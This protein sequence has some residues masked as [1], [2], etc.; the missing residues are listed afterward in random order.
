MDENKISVTN[1]YT[2]WEIPTNNIEE[3]PVIEGQVEGVAQPGDGVKP[4]AKG[5]KQLIKDAYNAVGYDIEDANINKVF[6]M[7]NTDPSKFVKDFWAE[8]GTELPK[9]V[10]DNLQDKYLRIDPMK[11]SNYDPNAPKRPARTI[12]NPVKNKPAFTQLT[13]PKQKE[14]Q[15]TDAQKKQTVAL[16]NTYNSLDQASKNN[17]DDN[18]AVGATRQPD[19]LRETPKEELDHHDFM[20]TK[21]GK[22]LGGVA[23]VGSKASHGV[24]Q[25]LKG[26]AYLTGQHDNTQ[27][28]FD[29]LD[30]LADYGLTKSDMS[31]YDDNKIVS[32][33]GGLAEFAPAI[34]GGETAIAPFLMQGLGT[35]VETMDKL[36]KDGVDINP[37]VRD[38]YILTSGIVNHF[39]MGKLSNTIFP[40]L[41][42]TIQDDLISKVSVDILQNYTGKSI[43]D[44]EYKAVSDRI[45]TTFSD[46]FKQG[47]IQYG[48]NAMHTVKDL[49]KFNVADYAIKKGADALND[50]PIFNETLGD[51]AESLNHTAT[52]SAPLLALVPSAPA[53][54]KLLPNKSYRNSVVESIATDPSHENVDKIKTELYNHGFE[55]ENKWTSEQMGNAFDFVDQSA[56]HYREL[57]E[58]LA[59][60][61]AG[62]KGQSK[63]EEKPVAEEPVQQVQDIPQEPVVPQQTIEQPQAEPV[64]NGV[65]EDKIA[66]QELNQPDEPINNTSDGSMIHRHNVGDIIPDGDGNKHTV[67]GY[68][69][70]GYLNEFGNEIPKQ[71][72][73]GIK[74][75]TLELDPSSE[76]SDFKEEVTTPLKYERSGGTGNGGYKTEVNGKR[77][78]V[79]Y[80][81][82]INKWN[83]KS[84]DGEIK[85][86]TGLLRDVKSELEKINANKSSSD[87]Q[88]QLNSSVNTDT[89][90]ILFTKQQ[91]A[92]VVLSK[93]VKVAETTLEQRQNYQAVLKKK[94]SELSASK[95]DSFN[96]SLT[97]FIHRVM[98]YRRKGFIKG[99][100][101]YKETGTK[102]EFNGIKYW[103]DSVEGLIARK[104][105]SS[106][107][108][109]KRLIQEIQSDWAYKIDTD[110][111]DGKL[112]KKR[113][114]ELGLDKDNE[115]VVEENKLV[116]EDARQSEPV[117]EQQVIESKPVEPSKPQ[118]KVKA[119]K[120]SEKSI[121]EPEVKDD[122]YKIEEEQSSPES[123]KDADIK[124]EVDTRQVQVGED[125]NG[126]PVRVR[127]EDLAEYNKT[128]DLINKKLQ[129]I[130]NGED[131]VANQQIIDK[132]KG[133]IKDIVGNSKKPTKSLIEKDIKE[134]KT[135]VKN[136]ET[137][138]SNIESSS[139]IERAEALANKLDESGSK[140]LKAS[141]ANLAV[142]GITPEVIHGVSEKLA[143]HLIRN[144]IRVVKTAASLKKYFIELTNRKQFNGDEM[145]R[146]TPSQRKNVVKIINSMLELHYGGDRKI[147]EKSDN[148]LAGNKAAA[149][150]L[151]NPG[152]G[153]TLQEK[154]KQYFTD[155]QAKLSTDTKKF[156]VKTIDP[157][158][159][160]S[161]TYGEKAIRLFNSMSGSSNKAEEMYQKAFNEIFGSPLLGGE[162]FL[163]QKEQQVLSLIINMKRISEIDR[164]TMERDPGKEL[165]EH[166]GGYSYVTAEKTLT[167]L[168]QKTP[169]ITAL[170]G[171]YN[172]G[173]LVERTDKYFGT[174]QTLLD[175][176]HQNGLVSEASYETMKVAKYYSPRKFM[177]YINRDSDF[178]PR[179]VT[180]SNGVNKI[181]EGSNE[182]YVDNPAYLMKDA[183]G[184]VM[185]NI[186][187]NR[188]YKAFNEMLT[189][190][191]TG[192]GRPAR[193]SNEF[194]VKMRN[195]YSDKQ[196]SKVP[197]VN[198]FGVEN[199]IDNTPKWKFIKPQFEAASDGETLFKFYD[200][201]VQKGFI[202][203]NVYAQ[204][205]LGFDQ[206]INRKA[207]SLYSGARLV[208]S[209][210]TGLNPYFGISN[211]IRDAG[212]VLFTT[213]HYSPIFPVAVSQYSKDFV[214]NL[215]DAWNKGDRYKEFITDG[216][217]REFLSGNTKFYAGE[218]SQVKAGLNRIW[219]QLAN[220][221]PQTS[222]IAGRLAVRG[223]VIK[224][225]TEQYKK[226]GRVITPQLEKE[227]QERGA[228]EA[229]S[230]IDFSQGGRVTKEINAF[231]P[232][233]NAGVLG[234]RNL[235]RYATSNPALFTSK[236]LQL[237]AVNAALAA[238]NHGLIG[239]DEEAKER[240]DAYRRYVSAHNKSVN[241][242][243]MLPFKYTDEDGVVRYPFIKI[244]KPQEQKLLSG[245]FEHLTLKSYGIDDNY[246]AERA[247]QDAQSLISYIPDGNNWLPPVANAI[248]AY[249]TNYNMFR[250]DK[251]YKGKGD[252]PKESDQFDY[253]K[254]PLSY[255]KIGKSLGLSPDRL[256][257]AYETLVPQSNPMMDLINY[258][259]NELGLGSRKYYRDSEN[260]KTW[261]D[262]LSSFTS[263]LGSDNKDEINRFISE[264]LK[265]IPGAK[266]LMDITTSTPIEE[267]R[268][269]II[270]ERMSQKKNINDK[271]MDVIKS[272]HDNN[273]EANAI[274]ED[275]LFEMAQSIGSDK[276]LG[277]DGA[278]DVVRLVSMAKTAVK[279]KDAS[280]T[281]M[282]V[283]FLNS[284][285]KVQAEYAN[286]LM[287]D[288]PDTEKRA[289]FLKEIEESN[290]F[291]SRFW[292]EL[293][294][295]KEK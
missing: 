250:G 265:S 39:L 62:N 240:G 9:N 86:K 159:F 110:E 90:R 202:M 249:Q 207:A 210:A 160:S 285:P 114:T 101:N 46:K 136:L 254:T 3:A 78:E 195:Y 91:I 183:I 146:M 125:A 57:H 77:V 118:T 259:A 54:A 178:K 282:N 293:E 70:N 203:K 271:M 75:A 116:S 4:P 140:K 281:A 29:K 127:A 182:A 20:Q 223:R 131:P 268:Q 23:Y 11:I 236:V 239:D 169:D 144:G 181:G 108:E 241:H 266:R 27:G 64:H 137:Q 166:P 147:A 13:I 66:S 193:Y 179:K 213:N 85:T 206:M 83:G 288:M 88:Q 228:F 14:I 192:M 242:V 10:M 215:K 138:K 225:I 84:K 148:F 262:Q 255:I 217:G 141:R 224:N 5:L 205:L 16:N 233:F 44:A 287:N 56:E 60:K 17:W 151:N 248:I 246:T 200:K 26:A 112:Y 222:E 263:A 155:R 76:N 124:D 277:A 149:L 229:A 187:Q 119:E 152:N 267:N 22:T 291:S 35:G 162:R 73:D 52:I 43:G 270:S 50:K 82:T 243:I 256:K 214:T 96:Q 167:D 139:L 69:K 278:T 142:G 189:N 30:K 252:A 1:G 40:K 226:E 42:K 168:A 211:T 45:L 126:K 204:E 258:S 156:G 284:D 117:E 65:K 130:E 274:T 89:Q 275:E 165:A 97:D 74:E 280:Q 109:A 177:Q 145:D 212:F 261:M 231:I 190:I 32:A 115:S 107:S 71:A 15:L 100:S 163:S 175:L 201:G 79:S 295:F 188:T 132:L 129:R 180:S 36:K 198:L 164:L 245:L 122:Y 279:G 191:D 99:D 294:G 220:R 133:K 31:N 19:G 80:D 197:S 174:M 143:V 272:Y 53:F 173:E 18:N 235:F 276:S 33:V 216:G 283:R 2:P 292:Q 58:I 289:Q 260:K 238:W 134:N 158:S 113:L 41:S 28:T 94:F 103:L 67:F 161:E 128:V 68:T 24:I 55:G 194:M 123:P 7:Y 227:I 120:V 48:E 199:E 6:S 176:M 186:D 93:P 218:E 51:L 104:Q 273:G 172:F 49:A 184:T 38:A 209:M 47:A 244:P 185:H 219:Y 286:K 150:K 251:F 59:N 269:D 171:D 92:S 234:T 25:A 232:F 37:G 81:P 221:L 121:D 105:S 98:N 61:K 253:Q 237:A 72:F 111:R 12:A 290:M 264:S 34:A 135:I 257:G 153:L 21:L 95:P 102:S 208:Q 247:K 154:F 63:V 170:Y 106:N 196:N 8:N 157:S 87:F 230:T